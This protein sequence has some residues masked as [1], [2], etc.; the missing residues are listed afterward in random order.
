MQQQRHLGNGRHLGRHVY[1]MQLPLVPHACRGRGG[2]CATTWSLLAVSC[3]G[4]MDSTRALQQLQG[5]SCLTR[6][7]GRITG[8]PLPE[9]WLREGIRPSDTAL[10]G[11]QG[12]LLRWGRYIRRSGATVL[13]ICQSPG[14]FWRAGYVC[15][16]NDHLQGAVCVRQVPCTARVSSLCKMQVITSSGG[17]PWTL[18]SVRLRAR[19]SA[20]SACTLFSAAVPSS[21]R[22]AFKGWTCTCTS[23]PLVHQVGASCTTHLELLANYSPGRWASD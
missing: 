5:R 16:L 15:I 19:F 1:D 17:T 13:I 23:E 4:T 3:W 14:F 8:R 18:D 7:E 22:R 10:S 2:A 12:D 6:R 11:L 21:T 9:G 20:S